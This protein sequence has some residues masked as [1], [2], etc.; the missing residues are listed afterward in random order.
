MSSKNQF[1][2]IYVPYTQKY[3]KKKKYSVDSLRFPYFLIYV[4]KVPHY[5]IKRAVNFLYWERSGRNK[6]NTQWC[7][8]LLAENVV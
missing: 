1:P 6:E 5:L 7:M 2:N 3:P 8:V 4:I